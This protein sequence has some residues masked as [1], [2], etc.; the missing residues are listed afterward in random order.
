MA[1]KNNRW[2]GV[3]M[4]EENPMEEK[5]TEPQ[6]KVI[7]RINLTP[8]QG[9][10]FQKVFGRKADSF[11]IIEFTPDEAKRLAPGVLKAVGLHMDCW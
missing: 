9:K 11:A 10:V 4:V 2:P 5:Q 3:L 6:R 1:S 8:E 7:E